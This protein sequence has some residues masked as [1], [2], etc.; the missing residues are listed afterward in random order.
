MTPFQ[1]SMN[2]EF[3]GAYSHLPIEPPEKSRLIVESTSVFIKLPPGQRAYVELLTNDAV[4]VGGRIYFS[5]QSQGTFDD[6]REVWT[7]AE[8]ARLYGSGVAPVSFHIVRNAGT[9]ECWFEAS[10]AGHLSSLT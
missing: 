5:L 2:I 6:G 8:S 10:I 7:A 3:T 9:G 1:M 4:M